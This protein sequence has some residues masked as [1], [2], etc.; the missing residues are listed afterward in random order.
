M[1]QT[2][3]I[4]KRWKE[5]WYHQ[6]LFNRNYDSPLIQ[7]FSENE[8]EK[9][10][11]SMLDTVFKPKMNLNFDNPRDVWD[12]MSYLEFNSWVS[13][14]NTWMSISLIAF[15]LHKLFDTILKELA[16]WV[17]WWI[18]GYHRLQTLLKWWMV[19]QFYTN[20]E[21][22]EKL[23]KV[24]DGDNEKENETVLYFWGLL[25]SQ[26]LEFTSLNSLFVDQY[27]ARTEILKNV[28]EWRNI[29]KEKIKC[30]Y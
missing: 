26:Y 3:S 5:Q 25:V 20:W 1:S 28:V 12:M 8:D 7:F 17:L 11:K 23:V 4:P 29:D 6:Y 9:I 13:L 16:D 22:W 2:M 21:K 24:L 19:Y 15:I 30:M 27:L 14:T 18:I 10:L